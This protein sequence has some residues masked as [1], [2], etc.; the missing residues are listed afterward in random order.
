[1]YVSD[2]WCKQFTVKKIICSP[3]VEVLCL[4]MRPHYLPREFGNII[5]AAVYVPPSGNAGRAAACIAEC[6]H[7]QL[8]RTTG[9]PVFFLGDF[10]IGR[11]SCRER[12]SSP[13]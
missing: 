5:I 13:V 8:Q 2:K 11:A 1:M 7:E 4:S 3:D 12:V 9:A 10:K 6:A